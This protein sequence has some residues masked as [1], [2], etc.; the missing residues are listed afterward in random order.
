MIYLARGRCFA[1]MGV[2]IEAMKDLSVA[3]NLDENLGQAYIYRGMCA[4]LLGD[5]NLAFLDF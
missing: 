1:C 2:F 4:Y 5:N 3:L